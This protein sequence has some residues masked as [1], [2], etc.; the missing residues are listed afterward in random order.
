MTWDDEPLVLTLADVCLLMGWTEKAAR[1]R[2]WKGQFATPVATHPFRWDRDAVKGWLS[3]G[4][5]R[6]RTIIR[7]EKASRLR[8]AS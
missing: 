5:G 2:I 1:K 8:R 6:T 3:Q 4:G 7:R